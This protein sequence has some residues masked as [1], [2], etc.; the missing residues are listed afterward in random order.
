MSLLI[1]YIIHLRR[2]IPH[3]DID[4]IVA[5][6]GKP[7]TSTQDESTYPTSFSRDINPIPCHSHNDYW[8][9]VPLYDA[10]AAGCTGVEADVWLTGT[11]DLLVGHSQSS[12]AASRSLESLYID[13]LVSILNRQNP[14]MSS[15]P[16]VNTSAGGG[17]TSNG[18][19]DMNPN[20]TLTLLIDMKTDGAA[21]LDKVSKALE[22]LRSRGW[23]TRY[24]G[25]AVVP[26][27]ITV[28]GT[29][30]TPF[31]LL[32]SS[33]NGTTTT[34][35]IFFDAPLDEM[36]GESAP[37]SALRY[38]AD[39]SFYASVSFQK[40]VGTLWLNRLSPQQVEVIRGQIRGAK[41]KGLK[42]RY[43][44]TPS[45]PVSVREHVW[46]VLVKEGVGMLN[47]DD[48][49]GASKRDWGRLIL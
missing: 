20:A 31:D 13:P 2:Q 14:S 6:W 48:L 39:N 24:N 41:E 17:E 43:W 29:G 44:N 7:G 34:S 9:R 46:D 1:Y 40:A 42:A 49:S 22:P 8:R 30:N 36:W 25:T 32:V 5:S 10:L 23:L 27:P 37:A 18:V 21:T 28:V 15:T 4:R 33:V 38:S 3:N 26:A 45:W 47:V 19:F 35:D 12:L 16:N 11:G